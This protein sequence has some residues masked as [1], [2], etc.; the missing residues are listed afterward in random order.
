MSER[1]KDIRIGQLE[2]ALDHISRTAQNARHYTRRLAWISERAESAIRG[3]EDWK[4]ADLPRNASTQL[5]RFKYRNRDQRVAI[6]E[7]SDALNY[8]LAQTVDQDLAHGIELTE[9]EI[10]ARQRAI[11]AIQMGEKPNG[12]HEDR[13]LVLYAD[14]ELEGTCNPECIA[15]NPSM[16]G[17]YPIALYADAG[18]LAARDTDTTE[19]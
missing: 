6:A 4:N 1:E 8:L 18:M 5:Q 11:R 9:G 7:M 10:E 17:Q 3:D 16:I 12:S 13:V 19:R 14:H 15:E 2:D